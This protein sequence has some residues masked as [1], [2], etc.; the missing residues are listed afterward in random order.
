MSLPR[1]FNGRREAEPI[2][3]PKPVFFSAEDRERMTVGYSCTASDDFAEYRQNTREII[4][5]L[6]LTGERLKKVLGQREK[7]L[8]EAQMQLKEC[9][10]EL[11]GM[12]RDDQ[13]PENGTCRACKWNAVRRERLE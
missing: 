6:K 13:Y 3:Q 2:Q 12:C 4:D 11:C 5:G 8:A 10:N 9:V 1:L 7:E